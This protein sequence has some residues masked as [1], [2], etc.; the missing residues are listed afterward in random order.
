MPK[1]KPVTP[2]NMCDMQSR[3]NFTGSRPSRMSAAC[4]RTYER[5]DPYMTDETPSMT[6]KNG[7]GDGGN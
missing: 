5:A 4:T 2:K 3:I 6:G 1:T 7:K